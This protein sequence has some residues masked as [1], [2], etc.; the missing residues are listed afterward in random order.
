MRPGVRRVL[1]W[2]EE[3]LGI[4]AALGPILRHR[5]PRGAKWWYVFGSAT[6]T[7]FLL[8]VVTGICL[9]M[10]Y[11]P[12]GD[13]AYE[14]LQYLNYTQPLG[15]FLR[16]MHNTAAGG[17]VVMLV[18]HM[19]QVFLMGAY[20]YPR[21]LTWLFGVGL[22]AI[23][24]GMAFSGQVL[25][26]D[27]D[28]YWG[29][30]VGASMAGRLPL[31]G[32]YVVK[33]L[34]S[35]PTI[36]GETLSRFFALHVFVLPGLLI[37]LVA[38]HLY[39]VLRLG[40]SSPPVAGRPVDPRTYH[41]EYEK[42]L[43]SGVPFYPNP[44]RRDMIFSALTVLVIV[45]LAAVI[46]PKGP[47]EPPDPTIITA[48]PRPDW[49]F[50]PLFGLLALLPPG[51]ETPA[52]FGIPGVIGLVLVLIPFVGSKG[53]RHPKRRPVAVLSVVMFFT[54]AG[55][56]GWLGNTSPWSPVMDAW[57]GLPVP[58]R[59]V[60]RLKPLELQGAAV[61][62]VKT[63][64]NCH[65]LDRSG[66]RRGPDLTDVAT[67]LSRDELIRQVIQ[68]GGLMPAFG[69]QLTPS[70]ID[71]MVAFLETLRPEGQPAARDPTLSER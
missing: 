9:A 2:L 60:K 35:G 46:G 33:M 67:K 37:T 25:R 1:D 3:R 39:L 62:Q 17:M 14:S 29:V 4:A 64:R 70:E 8:Q 27:Q 49:Y 45:V 19:T 32:P 10:V 40:I 23:T 58:E 13:Q 52:I 61:F 5:T 18:V 43:E 30:G 16:A 71:A 12:S 57:S 65:A 21:E 24:L 38:G 48:E 6:L 54:V 36:G 63:C 20:K 41:E 31:I 44:V 26:W 66:G 47:G 53:E 69:T 55:V 59:M 56:L 11:V 22:L 50:L 42:E 51:L 7:L 68:G 28:A 15:W 34:C